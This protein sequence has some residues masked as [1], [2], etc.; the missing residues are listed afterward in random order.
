MVSDAEIVSAAKEAAGNHRKFECFGWHDQPDDANDWCI[1]YTHN[2]DSDIL[3]Q[4][5]AAAIDEELQPFID[6]GTIV[7]EHHTH[8]LCGWVDGYSIRVYERDGMI[9][10]AFKK[11]CDI[12]SR[13]EDYPVLDDED[14]SRREHEEMIEDIRWLRPAVEQD[15]P[16]DWE[17]KVLD[18]LWD[19]QIYSDISEESVLQA[20]TE[21]GWFVEEEQECE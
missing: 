11:W 17:E 8:W 4:S 2:R 1:V 6:D 5:N 15:L 3:A 10:P 21:L 12:Q 18:W 13:L 19:H 7:R 14:L 9:T 16:K 20:F